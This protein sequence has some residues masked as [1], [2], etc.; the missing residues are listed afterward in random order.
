MLPHTVR[1]TALLLM[2]FVIMQSLFNV[3]QPRDVVNTLPVPELTTA[4][5]CHDQKTATIHRDGQVAPCN[6]MD[7]MNCILAASQGKCGFVIFALI[8]NG[9]KN[10]SQ[11]A[12]SL[13]A[14]PL[15][16]RYLSITLDV[17]TPPPNS[18][19]A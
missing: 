3:G 15:E 18:I 7:S 8:P 14:P 4:S 17:L 2:L 16:D 6:D 10:L 9:D 1:Q 5:C 13:K 12:V 11:A 19:F